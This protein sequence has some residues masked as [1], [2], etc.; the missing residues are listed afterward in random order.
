MNSAAGP[1]GDCKNAILQHIGTVQ[2]GGTLVAIHADS[3]LIEYCSANSAE[4]HG[5]E[6]AQLLGQ[7]GSEWLSARWPGLSA[8]AS[9]E[10][11]LDWCELGGAD[12]LI[13]IGHRQGSHL[14]LEF[15]RTG[16]SPRHWWNHATR[17]L[18][19][20]H[21]TAVHTAEHCREFLVRWVFERSGYDRVMMYRFLAG[22]HGEVVHERCRPGVG[23]FLGVRFPASDIPPNAR[24]MFT[25]NRQRAIVDVD[26]DASPVLQWRQDTQPL[27][28]TYSTLR[29]AHPAHIQYLKNMGVQASLTLSLVVNG[30]LWGLIACHHLSSRALSIEDR[31]AFDEMA[32]LVSLHLTNLLGLIEQRLQAHMRQELS[33]L[34]GTMTAA[35]CDSRLGLTGNLGMVRQTFGASGAWLRFE[36]EDFFAGLVPDKLSLAPLRD[37]L[38]RFPREQISHYDALPEALLAYRA[39][40]T[41]ASGVLFVPLGSADFIAL[42]RPEVIETLNWAGKP[43]ATE[44]TPEPA[45]PLTPR[46]SFAVWS[47]QVRNTAEPWTATELEFGEKLRVDLQLFLSTS[48]LERIALHDP[49]TGLANRLLFERRLQQE[50][51]NSMARNSVFAVYMIDLDRFK[52]VND[53]LGHGAG[54]QVLT[55]VASRLIEV[56]REEDTVAR[57]GGDEFA[58]LQTGLND[59]AGAVS[60]AER[61]V[62][63]VASLYN[64]AGRTVEIGASVGVSIW[65]SDTVEESELLEYADLALYEVKRSGRNAY[66]MYDAAMRI[67]DS[68]STHGERLVRALR[69]NEFRLTY[70]PIVDARSGELRGLEAFLRWHPPGA[71]V[72]Q[73]SEFMAPVEQRRLGPAVGEWVMDAVFSQYR[74]W[75]REGLA[76]VP[77]TINIGNAEFATQDLL[78]QIEKLGALY[79]TGWQWLRLDIKEQALV[80]DVGHA[81]R[82]L[83]NLRDAG[84]GTNLDNFGRGFV[85]LGYLTQLPFRGIKLDAMLFE[86]KTSRQHFNA[87]FNV[88]QSIAQV[89]GAQLTVT[90]IE[91]LEIREMLRNERVDRLQGYA[92]AMPAAASHA[93][94]WLRHP[95]RLLSEADR[96]Q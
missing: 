37:F 10:G 3:N 82:K 68:R 33:R 24:Q 57:L 56:V 16:T 93:V 13:V 65:P 29:A 21:L 75:L 67:A 7:S 18:F 36:G 47:Q 87:M 42:V 54:D 89:F 38:E 74:Q 1:F 4:F 39:L 91:T 88:V 94:E 35:G 96:R 2:A 52:Q 55:E 44:D 79:E 48:R 22:W 53:T 90:R 81:I 51:R 12:P 62:H 78:G 72:M 71:D 59:R 9:R 80:T 60:M 30:K 49:L 8:L 32:R 66:S 34:Q 86:N 41:N 27:D 25:V 61:I 19:V 6:P 17:T 76:M 28:L 23:G 95:E 70:Q 69:D 20:E 77:V 11:K 5:I 45:R 46:N 63:S 26:T 83:A 84:V 40:S 31:L 14:I 58:V 85:P 92:I 43:E 73:A 15:E 64:I 50:V